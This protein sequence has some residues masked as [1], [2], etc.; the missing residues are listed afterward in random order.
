MT[1]SVFPRKEKKIDGCV[2]KILIVCG[3][4]YFHIQTFFK[5]PRQVIS[6]LWPINGPL[7]G[8]VRLYK[9]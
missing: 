8:K 2:L 5:T 3:S 1:G 6:R 9:V 4:Q 7:K